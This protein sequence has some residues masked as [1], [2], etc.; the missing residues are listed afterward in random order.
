MDLEISWSTMA[1]MRD[2]LSHGY[3]VVNLEI[4]W[5]TVDE[6][7]PTVRFRLRRPISS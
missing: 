2:R 7:I 1:D 6:V 4:D 3:G 5:Q